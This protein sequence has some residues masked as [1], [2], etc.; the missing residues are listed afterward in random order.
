MKLTIFHEPETKSMNLRLIPVA[1]VDTPKVPV[2]GGPP[3]VDRP[4]PKGGTGTVPVDRTLSN[5][6][7]W[8]V[9]AQRLLY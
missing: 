1:K 8:V 7:L 3:V 9:P 2:Q 5:S 6:G 4:G